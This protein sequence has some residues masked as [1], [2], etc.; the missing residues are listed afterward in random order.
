[1]KHFWFLIFWGHTFGF[2]IG[3][4]LRA[5]LAHCCYSAVYNRE[6][7]LKERMK[8]NVMKQLHNAIELIR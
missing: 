7:T 2:N 6:V 1:M 5:V 3:Y 8:C 4:K